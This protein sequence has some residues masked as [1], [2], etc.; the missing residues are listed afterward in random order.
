M[1]DSKKDVKRY[2]SAPNMTAVERLCKHLRSAMEDKDGR[3]VSVTDKGEMERVI[4]WAGKH[5]GAAESAAKSVAESVAKEMHGDR[6]KNR[7]TF[8]Y[9][10]A[11]KLGKLDSLPTS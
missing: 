8:Y 2:D 3:W 11:K 4:H 6:H 10:M 1:E 5:L 7:V 9:L